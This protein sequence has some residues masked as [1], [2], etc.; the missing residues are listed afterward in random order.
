[1]SS[2][3]CYLLPSIAVGSALDEHLGTFDTVADACGDV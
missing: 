3:V 2:V 1:M